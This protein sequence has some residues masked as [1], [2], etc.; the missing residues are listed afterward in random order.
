MI[1][2]IVLIWVLYKLISFCCTCRGLKSEYDDR[3]QT[4]SDVKGK[5]ATFCPVDT[6]YLLPAPGTKVTYITPNMYKTEYMNV[7]SMR[8]LTV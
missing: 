4:P 2:I 7:G 8:P 6:P 1:H 3:F 5:E